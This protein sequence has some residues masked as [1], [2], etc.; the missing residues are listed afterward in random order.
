M[1]QET[2]FKNCAGIRKEWEEPLMLD[3]KGWC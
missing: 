1:G 2:S 3:E